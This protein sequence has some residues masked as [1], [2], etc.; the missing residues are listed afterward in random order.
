MGRRS[1]HSSHARYS[2]R[3]LSSSCA[4]LEG[5]EARK[6]LQLAHVEAPRRHGHAQADAALLGPGTKRDLV[7]REAELVQATDP[8]PNR[9]PV[10]G[11]KERLLGE[12]VPED[13]VLPSNR[14]GR[15][16][17][18]VEVVAT[19]LHQ[20]QV[21]QAERDV[22][23]EDLE[24]VGALAVGQ[25]L[26]DLA[27]LGV[28][29]VRLHAVAV[30]P[31]QRVGERA[32]APVDA[33]PMEVDQQPRHRVEQAVAVGAGGQ[34]H[35]Q[36][37]VLERMG[38]VFRD[39]DARV[40]LRRL[41]QPDR[42]DRRQVERLQVAQHVVLAPREVQRQFLQRVRDPF[43]DEEADEV[44]RRPDGNL[45]EAEVLLRPGLE[46]LL[47]RQVEEGA[48]PFAAEGA[49]AEMGLRE[50]RGGSGARSRGPGASSGRRIAHRRRP[51]ERL[52]GATGRRS[53]RILR[54]A[55]G[56]TP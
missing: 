8:G 47:P 54:V 53:A 16:D 11:P 56:G 43:A 23:D 22:L 41:G 45:A 17:R 39:E 12:L 30:P 28:H 9:E 51:T 34:P 52:P 44:P 27:R 36:P 29:E 48:W 38:Q 42:L 26:V 18:G 7:D 19:A 37:A 6:S 55:C 10:V 3:S 13:L 33:A 40:P 35:H 15:L 46:R 5:V 31:E 24:V 1:Y 49:D 14:L 21:G 20:R 2:C 25:P 50:S 4:C 32:V